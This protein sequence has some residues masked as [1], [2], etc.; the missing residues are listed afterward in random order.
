MTK[1]LLK[2][3]NQITLV[4]LLIVNISLI[5][6]CKV[7]A[8]TYND[9][10]NVNL[11]IQIAEGNWDVNDEGIINLNEL[12]SQEL[13]QPIPDNTLLRYNGLLY[14]KRPGATYIPAWHGMPG[15]PSAKW[16]VFAL[17]L[18]W[19]PNTNYRNNSVVT[20]NGKFYITNINFNNNWFIGDPA[21]NRNEWLE[22]NPVS[23][24]SFPFFEGTNYRDFRLDYSEVNFK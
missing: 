12:S 9:N 21:T 1:L 18:E 24:S 5:S 11:I 14:I 6:L 19:I 22:I 4:I 20:R 2:K 10:I 7:Y 8:F 15:Q 17:E 23:I 13:K 3:L 16:A